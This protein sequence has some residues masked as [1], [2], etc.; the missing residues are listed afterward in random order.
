ML[1]QRWGRIINI[2]SV[3]ARWDKRGRRT[4]PRQKLADRTDH[5]IARELG[6]RNI[7]CNAVA[8]GFIETAMTEV[9]GEES[10]R[11]PPN[12]SRWARGIGRGRSEC[13][14]VPRSDEAS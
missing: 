2:A 11:L 7:T 13:V 6:S 4:T 10:S 12:R 5:G 1:K 3:F 9:L 8:P 14:G